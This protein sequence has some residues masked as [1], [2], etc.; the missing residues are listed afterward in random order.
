MGGVLTMKYTTMTG[1]ELT[2]SGTGAATLTDSHLSNSPGD[3][4]IMNG[5]TVTMEY[6]QL[7]VETPAADTTHCNMHFAGT[8][9]V[10][11]VSHSN[12]VNTPATNPSA[13]TYGIMFYSGQTANFTYDNWISNSTNV[14]TQPGISGDFSEGY[15]T[16]TAP[17]GVGVT[18]T[19]A[20]T[21]PLAACTGTNDTVCAGPHP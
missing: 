11:K 2:T 15:F 17:S 6:S 14:D 1:G 12:V 10:I 8:G 19:N 9:N 3:L 4:L 7:G 21:A 5:G 20:A 16:G 18:L 13:P